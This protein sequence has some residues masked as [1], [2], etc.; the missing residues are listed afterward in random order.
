[1]L[2]NDSVLQSEKK[3]VKPGN[4][5]GTDRR[6]KAL[7]SQISELR[8]LLFLR[9]GNN[10]HK[11]NKEDEPN[12]LGRI[13]TGDLRRVK[14]EALAHKPPFSDRSEVFLDTFEVDT[15]TRNA[16]APSCTV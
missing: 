11:N 6:F 13:R 14:A 9:E 5:K 1:M 12:G 8:S 10:L 15:M 7:E 16:S 2:E 4:Q 3:V